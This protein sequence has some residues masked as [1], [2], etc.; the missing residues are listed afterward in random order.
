[1]LKKLSFES[2]ADKISVQR[3]SILNPTIS[4]VN[5]DQIESIE[6]SIENDNDGVHIPTE[7]FKK[8]PKVSSHQSKA[9][10]FS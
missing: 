4:E 9:S 3:V 1:L 6:P 2:P 8:Y 10:Y 5:D 7:S